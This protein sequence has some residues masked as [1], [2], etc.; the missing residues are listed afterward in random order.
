M[1]KIFMQ[2]DRKY[3]TIRIYKKLFQSRLWFYFKLWIVAVIMQCASG[4]IDFSFYRLIETFDFVVM[5]QILFT[6]ACILSSHRTECGMEEL[7]SLDNFKKYYSKTLGLLTSSLFFLF[8]V[9]FPSSYI[10]VKC[11]G[12]CCKDE[13][14][15]L[16]VTEFESDD[17]FCYYP[18]FRYLVKDGK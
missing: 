9:M 15:L 7:L 5:L 8:H 16:G 14:M 13:L 4:G 1:I 6:G 18:V 10:M 2:G 17:K 12:L 11:F 3:Y